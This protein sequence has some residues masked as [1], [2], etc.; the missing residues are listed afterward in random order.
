MAEGG[1]QAPPP[2]PL[3][4]ALSVGGPAA[5]AQPQLP[6]PAQ[7]AR[8]RSGNLKT[9]L[10]KALE[11]NPDGLTYLQLCSAVG[12]TAAARHT[13]TSMVAKLKSQVETVKVDGV[14]VVRRAGTLLPKQAGRPAS[15]A[16]VR[17]FRVFSW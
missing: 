1:A 10:L 7:S 3:P 13:L 16:Q 17:S 6:A 5:P 11:E 9:K 14:V 8:P 12:K 15:G 2:L 4:E